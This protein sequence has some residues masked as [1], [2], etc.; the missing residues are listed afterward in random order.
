M[1]DHGENDMKV[2]AAILPSVSRSAPS[3]AR[4][5]AYQREMESFSELPSVVAE[6][7]ALMGLRG[8]GDVEEG[9]AFGEDILRIKV[10]GPTGL[11]LTVVDLPG[12]ISVASEEQ[13]DEDVNIVQTLVD[14][15]MQ[16]TRTIILAVV[17]AGNDIANQGII[18]KSRRFDRNGQRTIGVITKPDLINTGT[19]RRIAT[20]AKNQDT[21]KLKLGFFLLKNPSPSEMASGSVLEDRERSENRYFQSSP[22]KEQN[23]NAD[24]V[25]VTALRT[26]LQRQ[27]DL[28][29]EKEL[30]KVREE[31]RALIER[32]EEKMAELGEERSTTGHF[33]MF[34][35][36]LAMNFHTLTSAALHGDYHTN[37]ASFFDV[38]ASASVRLRAFIHTVNTRFSDDMRDRG[39]TM[40]VFAGADP[41]DL[42]FQSSDTS[43]LEQTHVTQDE[44][45]A[46]VR[47]VYQN[48]R[49]RELPG[50]YN[51]VLLMEL[52]HHQSKRWKHLAANH[53]SDI[54]DNLV[55]FVV[56]AAQH[57][58]TDELVRTKVLE[59]IQLA[60]RGRKQEAAA[61]L[62]RLCD[63]ERQQPITYNHYYTDNVQKSR[64]DTTR[65]LIKKAMREA[66]VEEY[67]G[68]MHISNNTV[69]AEKLLGA[70]QRRVVVDMDEQ[71]CAE[72][73]A[74]LSA[75]YKVARKTFVDNVCKQVIER[76][77]LRHLPEMFSPQCVAGYTD[78]DLERI[79][80]ETTDT[81]VKRKQL[82]ELHANL[83]A[84]LHELHK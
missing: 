41:D 22:W 31:I 79:A 42:T 36:R 69:D 14:S 39:E 26:F 37:N 55:E 13:T 63:D 78:S 8:F 80:S 11:H 3:K 71:A 77:L 53:L 9:P 51:H 47:K 12:L 40:K 15:Y 59:N 24:R 50:N 84:S 20:L 72:A 75:Y 21:T 66:S 74:G 10:S 73:M 5:V 29:V 27:L 44:M 45:A 58:T 30:P 35:S 2:T 64:H 33:R 76:H 62:E 16:N 49:G 19:E 7:G 65:N 82:H 54:F 23:L 68:K 34:L 48:T 4:L 43:E 70:L 38:E 57:V 25:G 1:I 28:H 60:L 52:F 17:Q 67:N 18:Q 6:V 46:W 83:T 81:V 32:T 56:L 61:E